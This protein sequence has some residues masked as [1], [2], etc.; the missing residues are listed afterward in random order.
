MSNDALPFY[1]WKGK[2]LKYALICICYYSCGEV[3]LWDD[4]KDKQL[5]VVEVSTKKEADELMDAWLA[6]APNFVSCRKA[7]V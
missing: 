3:V 4:E 7:V 5:G 6:H 1:L 2:R